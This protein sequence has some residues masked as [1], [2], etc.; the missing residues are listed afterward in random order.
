MKTKRTDRSTIKGETITFMCTENEKKQI[1]KI[2]DEKC[3]TMS[4][5]CRIAVKK[6][7]EDNN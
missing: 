5:L 6:Y 7:I 1:Q 4:I 3:V 2:A